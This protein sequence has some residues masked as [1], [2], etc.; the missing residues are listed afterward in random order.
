MAAGIATVQRAVEIDA[1]ELMRA[2]GE[3]FR[4]GL[5]AQAAAAGMPA[6][7]SGPAQMPILTFA[8]DPDKTKAFAFTDAAVRHGVLLHPWHNMFLS[9]AHTF[10][11]V[12]DA[13]ARTEAAFADLASTVS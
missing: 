11:V 8:N 1:P 9:T 2:A 12:D 7:L 10:E 13:L 3:R 4:A 5:H 6:E